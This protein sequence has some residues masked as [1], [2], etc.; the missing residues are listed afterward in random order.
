M[1][2]LIRDLQGAEPVNV[3]GASVGPATTLRA[4]T[5]LRITVPKLRRPSETIEVFWSEIQADGQLYRVPRR[6]LELAVET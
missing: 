3:S 6:S 2:H 4:G 5:E 1:P